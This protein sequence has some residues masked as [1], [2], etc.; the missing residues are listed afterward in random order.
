MPKNSSS[1]K[2][3]GPLEPKRNADN[4]REA[5]GMKGMPKS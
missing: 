3:Q 5:Q 1:E 2:I 4:S